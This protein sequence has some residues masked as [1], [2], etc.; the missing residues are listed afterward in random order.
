MPMYLRSR[1]GLGYQFKN[2]RYL[3]SLT[4]EENIFILWELLKTL[5]EDFNARLEELLSEVGISHLR[6]LKESSCWW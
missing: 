2:P 6:K 4:V 3:K 1:L 5:K